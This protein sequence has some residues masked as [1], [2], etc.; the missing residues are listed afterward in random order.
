VERTLLSA[1]FDLAGPHPTGVIL[2]AAVL[3]A[4]RGISRVLPSF[5]I[6]HR[7]FASHTDIDIV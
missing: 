1:A 5:K 6:P 7:S 4:E 2:S 3:Q